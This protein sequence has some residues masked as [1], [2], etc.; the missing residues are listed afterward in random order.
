MVGDGKRLRNSRQQSSENGTE[1]LLHK[2][3]DVLGRCPGDVS[4]FNSSKELELGRR[5]GNNNILVVLITQFGWGLAP[6]QIL[7]APPVLDLL[8]TLTSAFLLI[9]VI[10]LNLPSP[11]FSE[12]HNGLNPFHRRWSTPV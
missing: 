4:V 10:V 12:A 5:C 1:L 11:L 9:Y 2:Y 6:A 3:V 8:I 7:S